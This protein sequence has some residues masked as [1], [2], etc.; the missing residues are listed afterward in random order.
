MPEPV[1]CTCQAAL[2]WPWHRRDCPGITG[3]PDRLL[4]I[5]KAKGRLEEAY[6]D[7][8]AVMMSGERLYWD[9]RPGQRDEQEEY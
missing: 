7:G 6:M 4:A 2:P 5:L 8:D 9:V 3:A 1:T